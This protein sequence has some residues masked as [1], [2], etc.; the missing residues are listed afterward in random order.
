MLGGRPDPL[1]HPVEKASVSNGCFR[2][3]RS[4]DAERGAAARSGHMRMLSEQEQRG[5]RTRSGRPKRSHADAFGTSA[6][7]APNKDRI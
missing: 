4:A 3:K 6:A 2:N 1:R 5:C 7:R